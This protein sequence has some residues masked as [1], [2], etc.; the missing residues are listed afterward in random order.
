MIDGWPIPTV[1][2]KDRL[3]YLAGCVTSSDSCMS[4]KEM[5]MALYSDSRTDSAILMNE[6]V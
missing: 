1:L 2:G 3:L 6:M 5:D 4:Y